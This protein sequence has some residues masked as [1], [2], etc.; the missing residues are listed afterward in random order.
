[1]RST[2]EM[3]QVSKSSSIMCP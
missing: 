3:K 1:M 2:F